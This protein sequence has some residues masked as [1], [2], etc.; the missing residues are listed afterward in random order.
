M[1]EP[2][3]ALLWAR[4]RFA[5]GVRKLGPTHLRMAQDVMAGKHDNIIGSEVEAYR[6]GPSAAQAK[7]DERVAGLREAL[8]GMIYETTCLS[9][10]KPNGDHDCTIK[11]ETLERARA[12]LKGQSNE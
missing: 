7:A 3:E 11:A 6:A 5:R 4:E 9:P 12:A 1:S 2:D 10:M 8:R